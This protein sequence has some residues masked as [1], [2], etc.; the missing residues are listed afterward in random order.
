MNK[1]KLVLPKNFTKEQVSYVEE[2]K[3]LVT[4]MSD[5]TDMIF[6]AKDINSKHIISTNSY[7][8]IVGLK[9]GHEVENRFDRDMPC[10]GTSQYADSYVRED[11]LLINSLEINKVIS[12]LNVHHYSDGVKARI[13]KKYILSHKPSESILGTIY[14]GYDIELKDVLK[15]LPIYITRFGPNNSIQSI[16]NNDVL[17]DQVKLTNYEQEL[18]F[19]FL[20]NWEFKQ[21][22]DFMNKFRPNH[23]DRT[24]DT[25]IKKKNYI[26]EKLNLKSNRMK[27]LQDFLISIGF[28][29]KMPVSFYNQV[30]GSTLLDKMP[31]GF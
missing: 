2:F 29:N 23:T 24:A 21:I 31:V 28:H 11:L 17:I 7:A 22:A 14:S 18:C 26:C 8:K 3:K 1:Y 9:N 15:I 25:V 6:G 20:L 19:L 4:I 16:N 30:I 10:D 12:T 27:D 5:N 13:F